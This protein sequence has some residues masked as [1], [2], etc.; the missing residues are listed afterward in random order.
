MNS[1][2][3]RPEGRGAISFAAVRHMRSALSRLARGG[4]VVS[5]TPDR[6][7]TSTMGKAYVAALTSC[8]VVGSCRLDKCCHK[9]CSAVLCH[10]QYVRT[11]PAARLRANSMAQL[12]DEISI[13][14]RFASSGTR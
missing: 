9:H 13:V 5:I 3:S 1:P 14:P 11:R 8:S 4:R 12:L 6:F 2:F 10:R 7:T